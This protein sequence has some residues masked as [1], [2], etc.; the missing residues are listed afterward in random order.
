MDMKVE[1]WNIIKLKITII[2]SFWQQNSDDLQW[3]GVVHRQGVELMMNKEN[4]KSCLCWEGTNNG[5]LIAHFMTKKFRV[6]AIIVYT[7]VEPTDRD[8]SDSEEY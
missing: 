1:T 2:H 8:T 4:A 7:P 3:K 5:I 6:S